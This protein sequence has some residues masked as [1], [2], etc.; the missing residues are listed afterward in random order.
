QDPEISLTLC[1]DA[2]AAL[3][4][5]KKAAKKAVTSPLSVEDQALRD[6]IAAAYF[7]QGEQL[8]G[9]GYMELAQTSYKKAEKWG[10]LNPRKGSSPAVSSTTNSAGCD[11]ARIPEDIFPDNM[12]QPAVECKLPHADE[13]LGDTSQLAYCLSLLQL[14]PSPGETLEAAAENWVKSTQKNE[15]EKERL[16][17]LATDLIRAFNRDELKDAKAVAEVVCLGPVLEK[18]D[19]QHLLR[20]FVNGIEQSRLLDIHSLEGLA[21]L[22]QGASPG[23][24]DPDDL[25]TILHI[26]NTRLQDTH[27]QSPAHIYHLT[28]AVS[29]VLDAMADTKVSGLKRVELHEPLSAYLNGLQGSKD[30][31]LVYQAAYAFQALQ[32]VPDNESPWQATMRRTGIVLKGV[33]GLVSAV[34]GLDVNGF[35]AGLGHLQ[36]GLG[37]MIQVAKIGYE[38]VSSLVES[39]QGLLESLKVG[40]SFNQKRAWYTALRGADT[41]LQDGQLAKF[42]TLVCEAPC[43]N[44]VAFQ[45]G[46]CQRLGDLTA[47]PMWD[48]ESRHGALAFLGEIYR[49]DAEWGQQALVKQWILHILMQL[50]TVGSVMP[51]CIKEDLCSHPLKIALPTPSSPSLLDRVQNKPDVETDLRRL[52]KQRL[53]ERDDAVYIS[54]QAKAGLQA[55]DDALFP[56]MDKVN[57]FLSSDQKVILLLGDSGAGKSTFNRALECEL[58]GEYKKKEGRIPLLINLPTIDKPEQDLIAKQLRRAEFTEPQIR[59]LKSYRKFILIC[60]GY[61]ES[62]QTH[63]L[64]VSNRLNQTGE[65][66]AQV[67]ISC[68]SEYLGLDYRDRFQPADRNHQAE[69]ALFQEAVIAPFSKDQVQDYIRKYVSTMGPLWQ[70]KDYLHALDN[71][72]GLQDLVKNPFML[73]MSLEVLPRMV[74]PRQDLSVVRVTRVALYDQFMEQ[75]LERGKKRLGEK[76]LGLRARADFERLNDEGFTQNGMDFLKDLAGAVYKHQAGNPVIAYSHKRDQETWKKCFFSREDE[77]QLLLEASPLTR[78]GNQY[79]FVHKSILEYC[80]ARAVYEPQEFKGISSQTLTPARRG[81]TCSSYSF[82]DRDAPEEKPVTIQQT[83]ADHPLSW[84]S[85][86]N[87]PSILQF[88]AERVQQE[89]LF[90]QQL[91]E[92]IEHSKINRKARKAA[93]NAITILIRAGIRFNGADLKGIQIPGADLSYGEFDSAQLQGADLRTANLCDIW[94]REA[95]LDGARMNGV[96]FG[97]LPFLKEEDEVTICIYSPYG[98]TFAV[99]IDDGTISVYATSKW[100]KIW[101][102]SGHSGE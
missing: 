80:V 31:F 59:E 70:V 84:R 54:P 37:E 40:L 35:I 102:L 92:M 4:R 71:I 20:L 65:W 30:P 83:L 34:K 93:A 94:L 47:N 82:H 61:D 66:S 42:K 86:V 75:W 26:L 21:Q 55:P 53:M 3:S 88:L 95:N 49:N 51:G 63:N 12:R 19:F 67:V 97:E 90:K 7:E 29:N 27:N 77:N 85:F 36:D 1:N 87:E 81:S 52:R 91:L 6:G 48:A 43:R 89:P 45:L 15:E 78:S 96:Q 24:L 23:Y 16:R 73:T 11:I 10:H 100:E 38:G 74:D 62:Q 14:T 17:M 2:A 13:R 99:G 5:M 79:R 98:K 76:E 44:D 69:P 33:S 68:R 57:E 60:D 18:D 56:L 46:V 50:A 64:Y 101:T 72:P 28:L 9:L 32:C 8:V 22:M 39:G 58:W 25:V 41:L